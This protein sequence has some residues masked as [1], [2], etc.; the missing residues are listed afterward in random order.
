MHKS[1]R[2]RFLIV[3]SV[4]ALVLASVIF[5]QINARTSAAQRIST[6]QVVGKLE[7]EWGAAIVRRD[8]AA[9]RRLSADGYNVKDLDGTVY[10]EPGILSHLRSNDALSTSAV[11]ERIKLQLYENVAVVSGFSTIRNQLKANAGGQS[12]QWVDTWIDVAGKGWR[13]ASGQ[14]LS[15]KCA[16]A[17]SNGSDVSGC[18]PAFDSLPPPLLPQKTA[19]MM[20]MMHQT[21]YMFETVDGNVVPAMVEGPRG[22]QV[23][24]Q[25][26]NLPCSYLGL[27]KLYASGAPIPKELEM[28]RQELGKLVSQLDTVSD[29]LLRYK[30]LDQACADG[31]RKTSA[32]APN[33]GMHLSNRSYTWDG[34]FDLTK[35][36]ILLV[37]MDGGEKIPEEKAGDC[38]NGKWAGNRQ[39]E[40]VGA[41]FLIPTVNFG[42]NHPEGFAG[43]IDNW[44]V[45]YGICIDPVPLDS[46]TKEQCLARGLKWVE[47]AGWMIHA[48]VMPEFDNP[49]G[50]F[51][52][53][54][55]AIWPKGQLTHMHHH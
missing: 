37:G 8:E 5:G 13:I 22:K 10:D 12:Y 1:G 2:E 46:V 36:E 20:S 6:E 43:P 33:M 52:V 18:E 44:H 7:K 19:D 54:N 17:I 38:V 41:A 14:A 31:Y 23:R 16:I 50:V 24:C 39:M 29:A 21:R 9:L 55:P 25:S 53:F 15:G 35:P 4:L 51:A 11:T 32:Q 47:K 3:I 26:A 27:K 28:T 48:Y 30:N 45:H 34:R 40:V 42:E 49:L